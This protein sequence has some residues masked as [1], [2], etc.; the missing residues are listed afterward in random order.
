MSAGS[1]FAAF[2]FSYEKL[3]CNLQVFQCDWQILISNL[4]MKKV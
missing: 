4:N 2:C 3:Q 1:L